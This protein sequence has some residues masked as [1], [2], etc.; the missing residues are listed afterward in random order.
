MFTYRHSSEETVSSTERMLFLLTLGPHSP[1]H[2]RNAYE[3]AIKVVFL[4][5]GEQYRTSSAEHGAFRIEKLAT[6]PR[7]IKVRDVSPRYSAATHADRGGFRDSL[8]RLANRSQEGFFP[9]AVHINFGL[10]K[11]LTKVITILL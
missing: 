11:G 10:C 6:E 9:D 3:F 4:A 1:Y 2:R 7:C 8:R 5:S